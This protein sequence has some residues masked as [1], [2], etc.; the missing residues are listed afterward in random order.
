MIDD[1]VDTWESEEDYDPAAALELRK[2]DLTEDLTDV[3]GPAWVVIAVPSAG[4]DGFDVELH[5]GPAF[6]AQDAASLI[7]KTSVA[8]GGQS[9]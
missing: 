8:L 5:I 4:T 1:D 7:S 2:R 9:E 6:N 3:F